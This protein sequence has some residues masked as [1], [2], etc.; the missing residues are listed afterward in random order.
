MNQCYH[1]EASKQIRHVVK[2]VVAREE[3][4]REEYIYDRKIP[5]LIEA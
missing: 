5:V 2:V 3:E 1:K 4:W